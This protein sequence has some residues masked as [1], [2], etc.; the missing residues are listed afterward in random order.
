MIGN[1][2]KTVPKGIRPPPTINIEVHGRFDPIYQ[3][4]RHN[5]KNSPFTLILLSLNPLICCSAHLSM[6]LLAILGGLAGPKRTSTCL[7]PTDLSRGG[8]GAYPAES[9]L[10]IGHATSF[11]AVAGC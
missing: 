11:A 5:V 7:L 4:N 10:D 2:S 8:S 6:S 3:I 1:V 9:E